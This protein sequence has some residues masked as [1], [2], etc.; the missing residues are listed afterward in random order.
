[1]LDDVR[2]GFN[3]REGNILLGTEAARA[4][5]EARIAEKTVKNFILRKGK[6]I[7]SREERSRQSQGVTKVCC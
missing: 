5:P 2:R 7:E 1:M 6:G 4:V 3:T